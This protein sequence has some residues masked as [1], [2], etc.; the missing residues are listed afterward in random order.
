MPRVMFKRVLSVMLTDAE[1]G[2]RGEKLAS[3]EREWT[4]VDDEKRAANA[5]F[6]LRLKRKAEEIDDYTTRVVDREEPRDVECF[7]DHVLET[8]ECITY[9]ADTGEEV[10]RRSLTSDEIEDLQ[11]PKLFR[12]DG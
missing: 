6:N 4:A 12:G 7:N 1:V 5:A 3:L 11:Q 10:E 9:R 2:A 8:R